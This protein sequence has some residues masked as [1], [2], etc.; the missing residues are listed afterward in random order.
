MCN[1]RC[2]LATNVQTNWNQFTKEFTLKDQEPLPTQAPFASTWDTT[3]TSKQLNSATS[4]QWSQLPPSWG[5]SFST[6]G[7]PWV[8]PSFAL[9]GIHTRDIKS[10]Q[11]TKL[12]SSLKVTTPWVAPVQY[13]SQVIWMPTTSQAWPRW[14]LKN[15]WRT[16][17]LLPV[18]E[19]GPRE[20]AAESSTLQRTKLKESSILTAPS[21]FS[22]RCGFRECIQRIK[23]YF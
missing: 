15:F 12:D 17:S 9:A 14:L 3:L 18:I 20:A 2:S 10:T 6:T 7:T 1:S 16:A 22:D 11:S 5:K 21:Q 23:T 19:M 4:H 13:L 8:L